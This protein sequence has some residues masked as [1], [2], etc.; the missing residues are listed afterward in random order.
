MT[1]ATGCHI[2][3]GVPWGHA[4]EGSLLVGRVPLDGS[5]HEGVSV[6]DRSGCCQRLPWQPLAAHR[7]GRV[8]T[9]ARSLVVARGQWITLER[10]L[11]F[12]AV[13]FVIGI[14]LNVGLLLG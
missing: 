12:G 1:V 5:V 9:I 8:G 4:L 2:G 13:L 3:N 6:G 7:Q 10:G 11:N 14:G